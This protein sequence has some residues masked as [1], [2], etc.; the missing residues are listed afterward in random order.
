M[1]RHLCR[2]AERSRRLSVPEMA[3]KLLVLTTAS[4]LI[5]MGHAATA[6][7]PPAVERWGVYEATFTAAA[8]Y[9]NP[10]SDVVLS[11]DFRH[12]ASGTT[13]RVEGFYD[14]HGQG[15]QGQRWTVRFMPIDVGE[16]T[17][18]TASMPQ[19]AGLQGRS[20]FLLVTPP[21]SGN[22]GPLRPSPAPHLHLPRADGTYTF[23]LGL[24]YNSPWEMSATNRTR[25]F[26]FIQAHGV[27]RLTAG[28]LETGKFAGDYWQYN[29][30]LFQGVDSVMREMQ[31]R[32]MILELTLYNNADEAAMS[33]AQDQQ[34][35]RYVM[36]RYGA[37]RAFRAKLANQV[38]WHYGG[39]CSDEA[40]IAAS[41]AWGDATGRYF[42]A[43]DPFGVAVTP[44]HPGECLKSRGAIYYLPALDDWPFADWSDWIMKQLQVTALSAAA[45]LDQIE[46]KSC[47]LNE[48]GLARLNAL[49]QSLR[50]RYQQAVSVDE[51]SFEYEGSCTPS[52]LALT[53]TGTRKTHWVLTMAGAFGSTRVAGLPG[54]WGVGDFAAGELEAFM[55]RPTARQLGII[56]KTLA[57]LPFWEMAPN[58]NS[59]SPATVTIEGSAY[60]S[61]FALAK[62]GE[63]YLIYSLNGGA[64]TVT[65]APGTYE[66]MRIDPR[67]G[68]EVHL[69]HVAGGTQPFT[70]PTVEGP[71]DHQT[72]PSDWALLYRYTNFRSRP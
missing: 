35:V 7:E 30:D 72:A 21:S 70:L 50:T 39:Y 3:A 34:Y 9:A 51:Y 2:I 66:V 42:K 26:D 65:L 53:G 59:V 12:T 47:L 48:R 62:S 69:G 31:M 38:D 18:A 58:P 13:L 36:A 32:G 19:D 29:L 43:V 44:H 37:F 1:S 20:G 5:A 15:D 25:F 10:F 64:G 11:V 49:V 55:R 60:P 68:T 46:P 52:W 41:L 56:A 16:W 28:L 57:A 27:T 6:E 23:D 4:L 24:W 14:G 8:R 61:N 67:D 45:T 33:Q 63:V 54:E 22:H 71:I 17:W 40:E